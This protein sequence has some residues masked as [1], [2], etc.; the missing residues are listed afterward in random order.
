MINQLEMVNT[1]RVR[2]EGEF[3]SRLL[4]RERNLL[5]AFLFCL[6]FFFAPL[7]CKEKSE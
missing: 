4:G 7:A 2:A 6:A 3:A 1:V 5:T